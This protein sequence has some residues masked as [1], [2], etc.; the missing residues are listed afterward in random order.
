M[1]HTF[2]SPEEPFW[3]LSSCFASFE[4]QKN[5]I[6][7]VFFSMKTGESL[8]LSCISCFLLLFSLRVLYIIRMLEADILMFNG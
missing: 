7:S 4:W 2:A 3:V 1:M 6:S 5:N 8:L